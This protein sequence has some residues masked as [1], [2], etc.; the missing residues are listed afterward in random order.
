MAHASKRADVR[1]QDLDEAARRVAAHAVQYDSKLK[2]LDTKLRENLSN[3]RAIEGSIKDTLAELNKSEQR[4]DYVLDTDTPRIR[5]E[6][7]RSLVELAELSDRLP[8]IRARVADIQSAYN[9]GRR[10]AQEL[11]N[12]L[13][14]LNT[15]FHE[16]WRLI[17]FTSSA[18]VS[19]RWKVTMRLLFGLALITFL[20]I[21]WVAIGGV[22]RAHRQ[23]L[24]WGER[25]M[26]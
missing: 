17:I 22:Y 4:V 24:V 10:K 19:W 6:L 15:D 16:R 8:R 7:D 18:P 20:W 9:S 14:W 12:D 5:E 21:A 1:G 23:R 11:V 2:N 3:F 25:L 26:S 13:V